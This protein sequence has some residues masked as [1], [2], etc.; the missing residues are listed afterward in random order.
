ML[1]DLVYKQWGT[2]LISFVFLRGTRLGKG[3][4]NF[5]L[6]HLPFWSARLKII[7]LF[8]FSANIAFPAPEFL[9][10]PLPAAPPPPPPTTYQHTGLP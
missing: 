9:G 7:V 8:Q 6:S 2:G 4:L 1:A 3:G 10:P 5:H